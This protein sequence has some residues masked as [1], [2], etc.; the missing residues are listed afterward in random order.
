M[1]IQTAELA[2]RVEALER[3]N[4]WLRGVGVVGLALIGAALVMGRVPSTP[5]VVEAEKF[6]VRDRRG[7]ERIVLGLDHPTSPRHSPVRIALYNAEQESSAVLYLS[8]GFA[9]L[10]I[11]TGGADGMGKRSA[12]VFANPKEGA[13]F[14]VNMGLKKTVVRLSA[15]ERAGGHFVLQD[16]AGNER[17][18]VP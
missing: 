2:V 16:E 6:V 10:V 11:A 5:R 7:E 15:D 4:R 8:D 14:K 3:Q 1:T 17:F 13:G 18:T 12:Q 9:G